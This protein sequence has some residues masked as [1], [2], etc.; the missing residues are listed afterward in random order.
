MRDCR[1]RSGL[2]NSSLNIYLSC[3]LFVWSD[4]N[5][6]KIFKTSNK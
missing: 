2:E 4:I 6:Y 5:E 1:T 3:A